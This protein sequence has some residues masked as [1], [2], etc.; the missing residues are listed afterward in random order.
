[1]RLLFLLLYLV[2]DEL[3]IQLKI[4]YLSNRV[5]AAAE[6]LTLI[7]YKVKR[8]TLKRYNSNFHIFVFLAMLLV[9]NI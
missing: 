4:I 6:C 8:Y 7:L 9:H 2:H 1:M 3:D 5:H